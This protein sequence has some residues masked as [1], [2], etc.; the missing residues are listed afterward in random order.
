M[1][2]CPK[3]SDVKGLD[4][5]AQTR[6]FHYHSARDIVAIKAKCCGL[7]YACKD[8]HDALVD[9]AWQ[10]WPASEWEQNAVL[11]GNCQTEL[12]VWQYLECESTCPA[13]KAEFNPGCRHHLHFYFDVRP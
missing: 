1:T 3:R 11:C 10:V 9:H 13:C 7:F 12:T 8:C 5:D 4:L 6:C 2:D